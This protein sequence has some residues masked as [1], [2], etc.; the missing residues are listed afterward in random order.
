MMK[1]YDLVIIG[2]GPIGLAC[3]IEAEKHGL[4]YVI[5]EK[6]CLTNS[7]YG[8]PTNM[9]FFSTPDK[10]EIGGVPF[11][12][13]SDKPTR[14]EALEYYRRV[15]TYWKLKVR[16]Y[17]EVLSMEANGQGQYC[18][19]TPRG[20]YR[21]HSVV[22]ATGFFAKPNLL[23][24]EGEH[25]WK[26]RHYFEDPHLYADHKI[27]VVGGG[28]SAVDV[29]LS[30]YRKGAEVTLVV[31]KPHVKP[32]IKFWV[33]P[34]LENR[35]KGNEIKAYFESQLVAI[36]PYEVDIQT[37]K[38]L[39]TLEND[40]VLAMTGYHPNFEWL[41]S[42][43]IVLDT[44]KR[45]APVHNEESFET[46]LSNVFVAGTLCGGRHTSRWFIENARHH[47]PIILQN[48]AKQL[49]KRPCMQAT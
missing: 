31:R 25:L 15:K 8:F 13:L 38:G 9:T 5:L 3:G 2:A 19:R 22:I 47:A 17:E 4:R 21:T 36:R 26:V 45:D 12:T 28:N 6:G 32:S 40:F 20:K 39:V 24:I 23:G 30:T 27:V 49:K 43:G 37:P 41:Q 48:I 10:I 35:V 46:N 34:D 29:A 33:K 44:H 7:I 14:T 18:L 1:Q 16:L 42:L 11:V